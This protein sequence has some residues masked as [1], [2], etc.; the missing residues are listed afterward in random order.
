MALTEPCIRYRTAV[1]GKQSAPFVP[2]ALAGRSGV[3]YV[4]TVPKGDS[5]NS[6]CGVASSAGCRVP[7]LIFLFYVTCGGVTCGW[8]LVGRGLGGRA[9]C[10]C[11]PVARS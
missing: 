4:S 1:L 7:R 5:G 9:M 3:S 8:Y 11:P 10:Q 2:S 6:D